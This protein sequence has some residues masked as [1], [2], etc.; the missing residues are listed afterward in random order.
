VLTGK[1][2]VANN[3]ITSN[4]LHDR[5]S[6]DSNSPELTSI[7]TGKSFHDTC[8]T[9]QLYLKVLN[10]LETG[11][12]ESHTTNGIITLPNELS[13]ASADGTVEVLE[14]GNAL[15]A[16]VFKLW[17]GRGR[18]LIGY[19][20]INRRLHFGDT[21]FDSD[22]EEIIDF[23]WRKLGIIREV[24]PSWYVVECTID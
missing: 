8:Q 10:Y 7:I 17:S 4:Q 24:D 2:P 22:G 13:Q 1:K 23:G 19:M 15:K 21:T 3:N 9:N 12:L 18:N 16:V 20:H 6:V 11:N 14:N 5:L